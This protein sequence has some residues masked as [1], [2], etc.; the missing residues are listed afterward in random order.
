MSGLQ[1][2]RA[3]PSQVSSRG[4]GGWTSAFPTLGGKGDQMAKVM[5]LREGDC[6]HLILA[7]PG[8]WRR[9]KRRKKMA[10]GDRTDR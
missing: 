3:R 6:I 9:R 1:V 5:R 10:R 7:R 2:D 4:R 8:V